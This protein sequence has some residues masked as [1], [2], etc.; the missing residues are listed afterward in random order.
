MNS[1]GTGIDAPQLQC[2]LKELGEIEIV[3]DH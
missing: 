3:A 2:T 1:T